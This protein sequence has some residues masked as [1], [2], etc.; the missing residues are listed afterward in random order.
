MFTRIRQSLQCQKGFTLMELMIVIAII[1]VLVAIA[2][3]KMAKSTHTAEV[4]TAK[5]NIRTVMGAL[6][7]YAADHDGKYPADADVKKDD[8][9]GLVKTYLKKWPDG[10]TYAKTTDGY[11]LTSDVPKTSGGTDFVSSTDI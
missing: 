11:T 9:T 7:V 8:G 1:G 3:P 10:I 4:A 6:E 5:A 2:L